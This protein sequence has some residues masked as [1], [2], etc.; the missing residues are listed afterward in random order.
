MVHLIN[1]NRQRITCRACTMEVAGYVR[2]DKLAWCR[3]DPPFRASGLGD[4]HSYTLW[5]VREGL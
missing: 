2:S 3:E 5:N 1:V 4:C